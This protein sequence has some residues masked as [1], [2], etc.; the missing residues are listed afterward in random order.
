MVPRRVGNP[1][2]CA[3]ESGSG[4]ALPAV[5]LSLA[6]PPDVLEA[7]GQQLPCAEPWG[8]APGCAT[9]AQ[10]QAVRRGRAQPADPETGARWCRGRGREQQPRAHP[11]ARTRP[12][13]SGRWQCC[14][15]SSR[16]VHRGAHAG[17]ALVSI[18]GAPW[19]GRPSLPAVLGSL[20]PAKVPC[21]LPQGA[22]EGEGSAARVPAEDRWS[23]VPGAGRA[24]GGL[25]WQGSM[26]ASHVQ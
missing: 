1:S 19:R 25:S 22:G 17:P 13:L 20:S 9:W 26:P 3:V 21:V 12:D 14:C 16:R 7:K 6:P 15:V 24:G 4:T 11:P 5:P 18:P 8:P 23:R 2:A 10:P